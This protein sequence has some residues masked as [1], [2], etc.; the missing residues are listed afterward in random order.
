MILSDLLD[1]ETTVIWWVLL[2]VL[3]IAFAAMDGFDLGVDMLASSANRVDDASSSTDRP[4]LEGNQVWLI[5]GGG[6]IFAAWPQLYAVSF[7][8][9]YLAMFVIL[10]ALITCVRS[11]SNIV[12]SASEAWRLGLGAFIG[13]FVPAPS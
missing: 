13:G 7:L 9:I 3:L 5:L 2:G 1:Y 6:A 11:G 12:P 10:F 4:R 8:R